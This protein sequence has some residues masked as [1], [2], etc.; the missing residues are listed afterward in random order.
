[1]FGFENF[2]VEIPLLFRELVLCCQL[3]DFVDEHVVPDMN[4]RL[5][6]GKSFVG[7]TCRCV[8]GRWGSLCVWIV[9]HGGDEL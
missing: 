9:G 1:M 3:L 2:T 7:I 6:A 8:G 5:L 4:Q